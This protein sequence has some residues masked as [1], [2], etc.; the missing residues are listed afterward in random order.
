MAVAKTKSVVCGHPIS[1]NE[2]CTKKTKHESGKCHYHQAAAV[3]TGPAGFGPAGD[4]AANGATASSDPLA[5]AALGDEAVLPMPPQGPPPGDPMGVGAMLADG[6]VE[7][8]SLSAQRYLD[9]AD[10]TY[11][12]LHLKLTPEGEQKM[13]DALGLNS[14][15]T[16]LV[17][18]D[19]SHHGVHPLDTDH[20]LSHQ[21]GTIARS[22]NARLKNGESLDEIR[23]VNQPR[24]DALEASF[25]DASG[26]ANA[27]DVGAQQMLAHYQSQIDELGKRMAPGYEPP[28]Y[29]EG[30]KIPKLDPWQGTYSTTETVEEALPNP[31][32][33]DALLPTVE[34]D[35][36]RINPSL[37]DGKSHWKPGNMTADG[38][39]NKMWEVD[40]GDGYKALYYPESATE[41]AASSGS[42][43]GAAKYKGA[44]MRRRMT[45]ISPKNGDANVAL[46]KLEQ[47]HIN[48][49]P[50]T[51]AGA[52]FTYLDR[53]AS[54]LQLNTHPAVQQARVEAAE[55]AHGLAVQR[56]RERATEAAG[57]SPAEQR[58][59]VRK[60]RVA[61]DGD[62][63]P[64]RAKRLRE[65]MAQALGY[66]SGAELRADK[67]YQPTP[68]VN[69]SKPFFRRLPEKKGETPT[70]H[71]D[72]TG[73]GVHI[74]SG[75]DRMVDIARTGAMASQERRRL[76]GVQKL[77]MSPDA[78]TGTRGASSVFISA[79]KNP[80]ASNCGMVWK[81]KQ[82]EALAARADWYI[83][84]G[85]YYGAQQNAQTRL[86]K[87]GGGQFMVNDSIDLAATPPTFMKAGTHQRRQ[88][89]IAALKE[90]GLGVF[91]DGR[92]A[93][94]VVTV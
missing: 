91:P 10:G 66:S 40:L 73:F 55:Y 56:V 78:D 62:A 74:T 75:D 22:Y 17:E 23:G 83:T 24:L 13:L 34:K 72:G 19:V 29:T 77:G 85:D 89:V 59:W 64:Y 6:E 48:S 68:V 87:A 88:K 36:K 14:T 86:S 94:D 18:K 69:A 1:A 4:A 65:G 31:D 45:V 52:E 93:E 67:H 27:K 3:P 25:A 82:A 80:D 32:V 70:T 16:K 33:D 84:P 21:V 8:S 11:D 50:M 15:V 43:A 42:G 46:G 5:N 35:G 41:A 37:H 47:L 51:R 61:A 71:L 76:M 38:A 9:G 2:A 58:E 44:S 26:K 28:A 79:S 63:L 81:G 60:Q 53:N 90:R 54:T 12:M 57:L 20:N 92:K 39:P 49:A 7:D 30:G